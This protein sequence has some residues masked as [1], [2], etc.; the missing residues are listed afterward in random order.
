MLKDRNFKD[1]IFNEFSNIG[2]CLSSPKRIELLDLLIS[3]PKSVEKLARITQMSVANVSKYLQT[4]LNANLVIYTKEKNYVYYQLASNDIIDFLAAFYQIS[5]N[6][7]D[8]IKYLKEQFYNEEPLQTLGIEELKTK[9]D[10]GEILLL[11]VR[12][13]EEYE[14]GHFPGAVSIP[15]EDLQE[16]LNELP[17]DIQIAAYCRG[18]LCLTSLEAVELLNKK[19]YKAFKLEDN[20]LD[21]KKIN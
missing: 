20:I 7:R 2:K 19:G 1:S 6:Q 5:E 14:H 9:V 16:K 21:W 18:N 3:G 8:S 11:D 4:L 13:T 10:N 12:S 17:Q 15:L